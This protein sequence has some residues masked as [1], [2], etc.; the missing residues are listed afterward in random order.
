RGALAPAGQGVSRPGTIDERHF[1]LCGRESPEGRILRP[2]DERLFRRGRSQ[3]SRAMVAVVPS[4][5]AWLARHRGRA[6]TALGRTAAPAAQGEGL[7][8]GLLGP[9]EFRPANDVAP[10]GPSFLV[11]STAQGRGRAT[12]RLA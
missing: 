3:R 5:E 9:R 8:R 10:C 1:Y 6:T 11:R 12:R 7:L 4:R 2:F